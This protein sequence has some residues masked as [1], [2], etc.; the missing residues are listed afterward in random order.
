[1]NDTYLCHPSQNWSSFNNAEVT[2]DWL[3]TRMASE[4]SAQNYN[5]ADIAVVSCSNHHA[6]LGK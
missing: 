4:Q 3:I 6:S 5:V 1:M 2:K